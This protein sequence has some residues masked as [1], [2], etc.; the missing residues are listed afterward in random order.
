MKLDHRRLEVVFTVRTRVTGATSEQ[1]SLNHIT[2]QISLVELRS[3][4]EQPGPQVWGDLNQKD[5]TA[6]QG[7]KQI[8]RLVYH[9]SA[10]RG[11]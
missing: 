7:R 9:P 5:E 2:T 1:Y 4:P 8:I 10:P 11:S 6:S 3:V